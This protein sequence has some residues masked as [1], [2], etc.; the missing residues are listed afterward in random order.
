MADQTKDLLRAV[1]GTHV[2]T[3]IFRICKTYTSKM[4]INT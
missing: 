3:L 1:N 4:L 2:N